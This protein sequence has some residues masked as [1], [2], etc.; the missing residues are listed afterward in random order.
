[1]ESAAQSANQ[2]CEEVQG[3]F[4]EICSRVTEGVNKVTENIG[5]NLQYLEK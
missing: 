1:M 5:E 4:S 3:N 2:T